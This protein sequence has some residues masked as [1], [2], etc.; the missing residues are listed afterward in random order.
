MV[1]D[2]LIHMFGATVGEIAACSVRVPSEVIKQRVQTAQHASTWHAL[3]SILKN[4]HGEGI[5][6]GLYRGWGTTIMR[7]IPFTMIQFPL[8]EY[9]KQKWADKTDRPR[10]TPE[11]GAVCGA[12]A[13]GVAGA[14]TNPLDVLK[15]RLMLSKNRVSVGTLLTTILKEEGYRALLRGIGPRIMWLS[16]GGAVFLGVYEVARDSFGFVLDGHLEA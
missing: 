13:G 6:L 15:T 2:G 1:N 7:E 9:C 12:F 5:W 8:Y 3:R 14:L 16:A 4:D 11:E 10:V